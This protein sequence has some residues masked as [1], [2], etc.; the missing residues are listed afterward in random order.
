MCRVMPKDGGDNQNVG[1]T[2]QSAVPYFR[3]LQRPWGLMHNK[4]PSDIACMK[5]EGKH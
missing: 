4:I 2:K 1:P 3:T 5:G